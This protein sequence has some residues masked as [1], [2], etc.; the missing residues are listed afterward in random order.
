V[1]ALGIDDIA[2][3]PDVAKTLQD[4]GIG[5]FSLVFILKRIQQDRLDISHKAFL[6]SVGLAYYRRIIGIPSQ[7][8][9]AA[10]FCDK[11]PLQNLALCQLSGAS[12]RLPADFLYWDRRAICWPARKGENIAGALLCLCAGRAS[13]VTAQP[14]AVDGGVLSR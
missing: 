11:L 2:E 9:P 7:L 3:G 10:S 1:T 14:L 4:G 5:R 13:F 8:S 6:V 12:T